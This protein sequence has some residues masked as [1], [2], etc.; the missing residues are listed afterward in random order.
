[1]KYSMKAWV[2]D[3]DTL[4]EDLALCL[5]HSFMHVLEVKLNP[6]LQNQSA[7]V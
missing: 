1:M 7:T 4:L 5:S 6:A 3:L 2:T